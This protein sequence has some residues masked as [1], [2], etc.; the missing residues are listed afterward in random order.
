MTEG[1]TVAKLAELRAPFPPNEVHWRAQN[2]T[3]RNGKFSA[4][5]LAFIDARNVMERL[6][7]VCGPENWQ[8][9]LEETAKGRVLCGISINVGGEWITKYDGAGDTDV[10][11][12]KGALSD[13][14]KRAAVKWGI[15][16]YLYSLPNVWVPCEMGKNGKFRRFTEDPWK[17]VP[18][19]AI[20]F[21]TDDQ[22]DIIATLAQAA[23]V[24]L[25]KV[26]EGYSIPD[27]RQL[28]ADKFTAV[29]KRLNVTIRQNAQPETKA[30]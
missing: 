18:A 14:L 22:R 23:N 26:C 11:G 27:L 6:D 25:L 20:A 17:H 24:P 21:V 10:E 16:R 4:L 12:E 5:A 30:A 8:D 15:G 1:I 28:P 7:A 13:A 19:Q 3:E 29:C 9:R 2:V